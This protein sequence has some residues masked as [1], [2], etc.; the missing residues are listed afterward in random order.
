[1]IFL[2]SQG[3][4]QVVDSPNSDETERKLRRK[5]RLQGLQGS[6]AGMAEGR[7]GRGRD[8]S[9]GQGGGNDGG[10]G[11]M[12]RKAIGR[13]MKLLTETPADATGMVPGTSFSKAGV[14]RLMEMLDSRAAKPGG[15]K[16]VERVKAFIAAKPG[17]EAVHG[18]SVEKLQ[19]AGEMAAKQGGGRG[20]RKGI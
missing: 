19:R 8:L 2:P 17:E 14:A 4:F 9:M 3:E 18:A 11:E 6:P 12:R 7:G 15:G 13:V 1:M 16:A 5:Q 10:K 20:R